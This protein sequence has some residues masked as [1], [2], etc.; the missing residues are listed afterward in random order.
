MDIPWP[1]DEWF[2]RAKSGGLLIARV[3]KN[4]RHPNKAFL[5][6]TGVCWAATRNAKDVEFFAFGGIIDVI[7]IEAKR[8]FDGRRLSGP[9]LSPDRVLWVSA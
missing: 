5:F 4:A 1:A 2:V 8:K 3:Q 9:L 7:R 6:R